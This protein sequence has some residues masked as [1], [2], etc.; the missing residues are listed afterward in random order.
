M[1]AIVTRLRTGKDRLLTLTGPG[2]V[3]KT[4]LALAL[5]TALPAIRSLADVAFVP[6]ASI[7]TRRSWPSQSSIAGAAAQPGN[8]RRSRL[9]ERGLRPPSTLLLILDNLEHLLAAPL[10]VAHLLAACP[11]VTVL[12]TTR[13]PLRRGASTSYRSRPWP[14]PM[15]HPIPLRVVAEVPAAACSSSGSRRPPSP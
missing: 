5:A 3:G 8:S 10:W 9:R 15:T 11:A 12:A 1:R 2:G 6:L 4:R 7:A 14:C 13:S